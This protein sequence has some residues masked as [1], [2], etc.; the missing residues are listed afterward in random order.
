[1]L[2]LGTCCV[3][4]WCAT[5][6][7]VLRACPG[8]RRPVARRRGRR[9]LRSRPHRAAARAEPI[10]RDRTYSGEA[11]GG[12][13][14]RRAT[15][16]RFAR[17]RA[18]MDDWVV[19]ARAR[20]VR[21]RVDR[22]GAPSVAVRD[23]VYSSFCLYRARSYPCDAAQCHYGF[24]HP[25]RPPMGR[26]TAA[27]LVLVKAR[28]ACAQPNRHGQS[29]VHCRSAT[30]SCTTEGAQAGRHTGGTSKTHFPE[31]PAAPAETPTRMPSL[32]GTW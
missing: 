8:G 32:A 3:A 11:R 2:Y 25:L 6:A 30:S 21:G 7:P 1:M 16:R 23:D 28:V 31:V 12:W 26:R 29:R 19:G 13:C 10:A 22:E 18:E 17:R 27:R 24:R 9:A 20:R 5:W 15:P 4:T 14:R